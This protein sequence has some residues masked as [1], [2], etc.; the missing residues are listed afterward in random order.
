MWSDS[1]YYKDYP[2]FG[3]E[4]ENNALGIQEN[5]QT[6]LAIVENSNII[7]SEDNVVHF[8]KSGLPVSVVRNDVRIL[9]WDGNALKSA[10]LELRFREEYTPWACKQ[11]V[12]ALSGV[13]LERRPW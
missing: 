6:E 4:W 9:R 13:K 8:D 1:E 3:Y 11:Y 5:G 10:P 7:K 2:E 12:P